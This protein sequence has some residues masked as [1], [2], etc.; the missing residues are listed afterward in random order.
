MLELFYLVTFS[1]STVY[2]IIQL[3]V[4]QI[5]I[6]NTSFQGTQ[7]KLETPV[8]EIDKVKYNNTQHIVSTNTDN[9]RVS[10][11]SLCF[12]NVIDKITV[13][14]FHEQCKIT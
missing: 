1:L 14:S 3:A 8:P 2:Y 5:V 7:L 11:I 9:R 13:L 4:C 12:Q 10:A 6:I